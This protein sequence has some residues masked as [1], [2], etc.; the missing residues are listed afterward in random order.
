MIVTAPICLILKQM[1]AH[2]YMHHSPNLP[3]HHDLRC[4]M[5]QDITPITLAQNDTPANKEAMLSSYV[6]R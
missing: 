3:D 2:H 1:L 4:D 6:S 5:V